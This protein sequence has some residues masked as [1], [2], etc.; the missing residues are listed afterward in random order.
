MRIAI[1]LSLLLI[2]TGFAGASLFSRLP[3]RMVLGWVIVGLAQSLFFLVIGFE[4]LAL[5]NALFVAASG[6]VL[7]IFSA[8]FGTAAIEVAE[9]VRTRADWIYGI[10]SG[11]TIAAILLFG[12][13]SILPEGNLG[14]DLET[15][16]FSRE[17]LGSFPELP[18]MIG[19]TLF[20][21]IVGWAAIGRPGWKRTKGG[22]R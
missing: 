20:L 17:L 13:V 16:A 9:R 3:R 22:Q 18:W 14:P 11:A 5:L 7:Q 21:S 4:L 8:L 1:L 15:A 6:T 12:F 10:G 19:V 2:S